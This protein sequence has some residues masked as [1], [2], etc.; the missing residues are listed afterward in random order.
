[1]SKGSVIFF[2]PIDYSLSGM[3]LSSLSG[4]DSLNGLANITQ[5]GTHS[6][7]QAM[8]PMIPN[9]AASPA[10]ITSSALFLFTAL[11][12][13]GVDQ[14]LGQKL[15]SDSKHEKIIKLLEAVTKEGGSINR[16]LSAPSGEWRVWN[17]PLNYHD[18]FVPVNHYVQDFGQQNQGDEQADK[19]DLTRFVFEFDLTRMGTLQIDGMMREENLDIFIRTEREVSKEMKNTI[20]GLYLSALEKSDLK[21]DVAFQTRDKSWVELVE[22]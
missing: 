18:Q 17:F 11:G 4:W 10:Q 21:G 8:A 20:R 13:G 1:M 6:L 19:N 22:G 15:S 3:S 7:L 12:V 14:W 9:A 16:S 2:Q 5:G